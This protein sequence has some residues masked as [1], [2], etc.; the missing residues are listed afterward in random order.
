MT[1]APHH[2][3]WTALTTI[4]ARADFLRVRGGAKWNTPGFLIEGKPA[5]EPGPPRFGFTATKKLGNAVVRNRIRRRLKEAVR[6]AQSH[7]A[8]A[9]YDY[10]VVARPPAMDLPFERLVQDFETGLKRIH[11]KPRPKATADGGTPPVNR[12][13]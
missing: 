11:G 7:L 4:K 12:P 1:E 8:V 13:P 6:K 5:R 9:G 3:T 2:P 10:V